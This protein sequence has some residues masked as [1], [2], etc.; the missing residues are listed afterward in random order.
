MLKENE[1]KA[2]VLEKIRTGE[3]SMRPRIYFVARMAGLLTLSLVAFLLSVFVL[4]FAFFS[5]HESGEQFL[6]GFGG[7]GLLVFA[8]L[9]PWWSLV[10][11]LALLF[12]LEYVLR[13]FKFGYR[14]SVLALFLGALVVIVIAGIVIALTPLHSVL[15]D[16][17][18]QGALPILGPLY[19]EIHDSHQPQGVFRGVVSSLG[20]NQFTLA[21]DDKDKDTD[22]GT[23]TVAVPAG[24][25]VGAL[26]VGEHVYVVGNVVQGVVQAYGIQEFSQGDR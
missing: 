8:A 12:L 21:H 9:F 17:A 23:S 24:F 25:D 4:S 10:V 11:T 26:R 13:Y 20:E 22:D 2:Q 14:I 19:E 3:A 1:I 7:R 15:L 18:D 5:I 6:L 16:S